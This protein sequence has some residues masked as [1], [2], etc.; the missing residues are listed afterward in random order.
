[1]SRLA[2]ARP[3]FFALTLFT[4]VSARA[5]LYEATQALNQK[6][7]PK[8]FALYRE[9]AELGNGEAQEALAVMYVNG[10]GVKRDNVAGYAWA[11]IAVENGS[12]EAAQSI[13]SQLEPHVTPTAR[14][15]I[16][17]IRAQYGKEALKKALLPNIFSNA[18][19]MDREPCKMTKPFAGPYPTAA[20][21][22]GIQG[23][24][25][26]ELT[27]MPDGRARNPRVVY[28]VP[29][30]F[31][32]EAARASI[33]K[34]EFQ[35]ARSKEGWVPCTMAVMFRYVLDIQN[36]DYSKLDTFVKETKEQAIAGDPRGQMLYG[37]LLAGL[38]QLKQSRS[39]AMPWFVKSAQ[40]G[41]PT[42]QYLVGVS[43][44]QGWGCECEEPKGMA[45]LHKAAAA[46]QSDAQVSIANYLL[47]GKPTAEDVAKART[48]LERAAAHENRDAKFYLAALL[49][50]GPDEASR[51]PK[52][53]LELLKGVM[54][55]M[56]QDPT[57]F[58][59]RAAANAMLGNFD[60]AKK[61]Q[62]KAL[63]MAKSLDW[64]L[65]PQQAR[66]G[67]YE[68]NQPFTGDLFAF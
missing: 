48:W 40:A 9:L 66:L 18:N 37:L 45:W 7:M 41:M 61:D 67:A 19:Y 26:V 59:I 55:D 4:G 24:A 35:P 38:P 25:Y 12:S 49:A 43:A 52:R 20:Y 14:V 3:L 13:V 30:G 16:D 63:K 36:S 68:R 65:A 51:D 2:W 47:R 64:D 27:V 42:A 31:F 62:A 17:A 50:A 32:E 57:S 21:L 1:M 5:D 8:A 6:D 56:D 46:D 23:Q 10:E 53:S 28:S 39:D 58:E 29:A 22:K 44:M 11:S 15:R 60:T 33:L 34:T 54:R